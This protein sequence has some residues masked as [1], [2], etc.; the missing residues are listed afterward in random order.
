MKSLAMCL[1]PSGSGCMGAPT[2]YWGA[3][4]H[5]PC[6]QA[7]LPLTGSNGGGKACPPPGSAAPGGHAA[8]RLH[9]CCWGSGGHLA[10]T[11]CPRRAPHPAGNP[12]RLWVWHGHHPPC[13]RTLPCPSLEWPQSLRGLCIKLHSGNVLH[14]SPEGAEDGRWSLFFR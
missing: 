10:R 11:G 3:E 12:G 8:G 13:S 14:Q 1:A 9:T 2:W 5:V 4:E 6:P 7:P